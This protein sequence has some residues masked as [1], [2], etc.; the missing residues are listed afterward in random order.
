MPMRMR[1]SIGSVSGP[2]RLTSSGRS[3]IAPWYLVSG[4]RSCIRL[5]QR[6]NVLLPQPDGPIS[7]VT[8]FSGITRLMFLSAWLVPYQKLSFSALAFGGFARAALR[9]SSTIESE[10]FPDLCALVSPSIDSTCL[11]LVSAL[12][13]TRVSIVLT[14]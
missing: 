6:R 4:C 12:A 10:G 8:W 11:G 5:K 13:S 14:S 2:T 3:V 9:S 1:T 7:A